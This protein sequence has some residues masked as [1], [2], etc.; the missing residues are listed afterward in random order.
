MPLDQDDLEARYYVNN[1]NLCGGSCKRVLAQR[2]FVRLGEWRSAKRLG[3]C[4]IRR[5]GF[6]TNHDGRQI[7]GLSGL[8]D[9]YKSCEALRNRGGL[10]G[11]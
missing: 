4:D 8:I 5:T 7:G 6:R 3:S 10:L 11:D 9:R 2:V 1:T